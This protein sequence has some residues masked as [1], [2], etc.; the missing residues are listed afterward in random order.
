MKV[1]DLL[2]LCGE[3]E[4]TVVALYECDE[5]EEIVGFASTFLNDQRYYKALE[6]DVAS[7]DYEDDNGDTILCI[8]Y[9][10]EEN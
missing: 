7:W 1:K 10:R 8:Y 9:F 6:S 3:K 4:S 2:R 5:R